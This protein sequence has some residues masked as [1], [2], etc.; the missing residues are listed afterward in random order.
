MIVREAASTAR[1]TGT[2]ISDCE[3]S[4]QAMSYA[5]VLMVVDRCAYRG[6]IGMAAFRFV[7][8]DPRLANIPLILETPTFEE[9]EVWRR[10]MEILYEL[11]EV[12][13]TEEEVEA[14][15]KEM[16]E[17]WREELKAMREKSGKG[18]KPKPAKNESAPKAKGKKVPAAKKGRGKKASESEEEEEE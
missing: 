14:K 5:K 15:L 2:T 10:E 11:Q 9:T 6:E 18:P 7:V 16:T 8:Q 13:G 17:S 3:F 1:R 12:D 4:E